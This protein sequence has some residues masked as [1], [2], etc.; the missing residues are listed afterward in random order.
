MAAIDKLYGTSYERQELKTWLVRHGKRN[1]AKRCIYDKVKG[2]PRNQE[3]PIARFTIE[4][5]RWLYLHCDLK[6]LVERIC[7]WSYN[8]KAPPLRRGEVE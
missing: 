6:W 3:R 8:G 4:D 7:E 1:W 2:I 5:D